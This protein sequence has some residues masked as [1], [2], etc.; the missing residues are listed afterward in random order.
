MSETPNPFNRK[1]ISR[2]TIIAAAMAVGGIILFIVLW[3]VLGNTGIDQLARLLV[4]F[5]VPPAI[6][7]A[8]LGIY[9]LIT[10]NRP[11]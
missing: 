11:H 3:I 10:H 1:T 4:S 8:L 6:I 5:C 7:T 9:F 2:A